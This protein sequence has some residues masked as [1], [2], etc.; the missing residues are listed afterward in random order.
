MAIGNHRYSS[1]NPSAYTRTLIVSTGSPSSSTHSIS[2]VVRGKE[3]KLPQMLVLPAKLGHLGIFFLFPNGDLLGRAYR[4][5]K[6]VNHGPEV[7]VGNIARFQV[8]HPLS[9]PSVR[10][11]VSFLRPDK[12]EKYVSGYSACLPLPC[13]WAEGGRKERKRVILLR[14]HLPPVSFHLTKSNV[15]MSSSSVV[16]DKYDGLVLNFSRLSTSKR[17][18]I[19]LIRMEPGR[20]SIDLNNS[21]IQVLTFFLL[22]LYGDGDI[23]NFSPPLVSALPTITG[24]KHR[25][26]NPL[27][28]QTGLVTI[29]FNLPPDSPSQGPGGERQTNGRIGNHRQLLVRFLTA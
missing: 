18:D 10:S 7:S 23:F 22:F 6:L 24:F 3:D 20:R 13:F 15:A 12:H 11:K 14:F 26:S 16:A 17:E 28:E 8:L 1:L 2:N 29:S 21:K 4:G 5:S 27:T 25:T 19:K 9:W